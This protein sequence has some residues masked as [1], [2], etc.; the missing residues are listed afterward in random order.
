[1]KYY[2]GLLL[3]S[4]MLAGC[5]NQSFSEQ[6]RT[7]LPT[8]SDISMSERYPVGFA[9]ATHNV[10]LNTYAEQIVVGLLRNGPIPTTGNIAVAS[11]VDFDASLRSTHMLGNQLAENLTLQLQK[12]G[13]RVSETK[14]TAELVSNHNG[15][16]VLSR[17]ERRRNSTEQFCCIL[18]G[19]L[20]Y[21]PNG[22]AVNSRLFDS[23]N[24]S[25]L[26]SSQVTIPYF[27]THYLGIVR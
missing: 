21:A 24:H 2:S 19:T 7:N 9:P 20:I 4:L 6:D 3:S 1:M 15:D 5:Q 22:I 16:F 26:S 25:L 8:H 10:S 12:F 18:T 14:A 27:V 23:K 17:Q 11:Y 13:Y